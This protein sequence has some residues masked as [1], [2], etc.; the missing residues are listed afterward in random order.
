MIGFHFQVKA[1]KRLTKSVLFE[2]V[3]VLAER[4]TDNVF[5]GFRPMASASDL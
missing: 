2:R 4:Q 5:H 3:K 1:R